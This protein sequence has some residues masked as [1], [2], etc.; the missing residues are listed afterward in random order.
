MGRRGGVAR[1]AAD[2]RARGRHVRFPTNNPA[3]RKNKDGG[4]VNAFY[5]AGRTCNRASSASSSGLHTDELL[6]SLPIVGRGLARGFSRVR[7]GGGQISRGGSQRRLAAAKKTPTI[8]GPSLFYEE[9]RRISRAGA[10]VRTPKRTDEWRVDGVE[11][12]I[13]LTRPGARAAARLGM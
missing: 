4:R 11:L 5:G 2:G 6:P 10:R 7:D 12:A 1:V 3:P 9:E 8:D 13:E